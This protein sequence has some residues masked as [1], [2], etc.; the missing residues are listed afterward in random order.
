MRKKVIINILKIALSSAAIYYVAT[1]LDFPLIKESIISARYSLMFVALFLYSLSQLAGVIRLNHFFK[2]I[3][4]NISNK[5]NFKL[6]W[7][8]LFYNLFLPG[9]VGGDGFKVY[10]LGKYLKAP[11]KKIIGAILS[12]RVSGLSVILMFLLMLT[13]LIDFSFPYQKFVWLFIPVVGAGFYLFLR[14]FNKSLTSAFFQVS[15]WAIVVQLLQ[16]GAAIMILLSLGVTFNQ[17]VYVNYLF[18]FF[19]SAIM[20]SIPLT[21]GGIGAREITY[22]FGAQYLGIDQTHAVALSILFYA[23]SAL[24]ALPG[25]VFTVNPSAILNSEQTAE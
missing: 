8:G 15:G 6:Y 12:D 13:P 7:L 19:L 14:F 1:S 9:G 16:M 22:L 23:A 2:K 18:L 17:G 20:G 11:I 10:L 5:E 21:L 3:P 4:L 25:I 24:T